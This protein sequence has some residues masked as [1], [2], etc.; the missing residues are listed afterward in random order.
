MRKIVKI[1]TSVLHD[2]IED[3]IMSCVHA[4][5]ND[6]TL[7]FRWSGG[8]WHQIEDI[9]QD[10][11]G[12]EDN[13]INKSVSHLDLNTRAANCLRINHINTIRQL[14]QLKKSDVLR[15]HNLGKTSLQEIEYKLAR[16]GLHLGIKLAS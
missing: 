14:I 7:W 5:C 13:I 12:E 2:T 16:C 10:G 9:P 6:G 1:S 8:I 3:E 4:L 11:F 15:L